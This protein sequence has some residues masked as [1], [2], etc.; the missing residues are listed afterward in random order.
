MLKT[1]L[2]CY[3]IFYRLKVK[4]LINYKQF[5]LIGSCYSMVAFMWLSK[6]QWDLFVWL[7][8]ICELSIC[9]WI[10]IAIL[11]MFHMVWLMFLFDQ[12][13]RSVWSQQQ[14]VSVKIPWQNQHNLIWLESNCMD[15]YCLAV[16]CCHIQ[17][18]NT[19]SSCQVQRPSE[20]W[21]R[22]WK[23]KQLYYL[24]LAIKNKYN[25]ECSIHFKLDM[26]SAA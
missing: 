15:I 16:C 13:I 10:N 25:M 7:S 19:V 14:C 5:S 17:S 12:S 11:I 3:S 23:I 2:S 4:W 22:I 20:I 1:L 8:M 6:Y 26:D 9:K 24:V 18:K 21:M